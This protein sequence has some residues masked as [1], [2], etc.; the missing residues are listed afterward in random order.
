MGSKPLR[1]KL[2]E[3]RNRPP[4][5][6]PFIW[7]TRELVESD[8]W[9]TAPI[10]TIRFVFRLMVE[11]MAHGGCENG[12][13]VCTHRDCYQWGIRKA[14]VRKAQIDAIQ[15]G[16]VYRTQKGCAST[17]AGRR[18]S[19]FGL[20]WLPG[21]DGAPAPNRWKL[22]I[23]ALSVPP[24]DIKSAPVG[25]GGNLK[26][27]MAG[28]GQKPKLA[29]LINPRGRGRKGTKTGAGEKAHGNGVHNLEL[30]PPGWRWGKDA[31]GRHVRA[32]CPGTPG[33]PW[34]SVPIIDGVGDELERAARA[35]LLAWR[36][37]RGR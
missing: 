27:R 29:S 10:W 25:G 36:E 7:L 35:E 23:A 17:G 9:Q 5:G 21:H 19:K 4:E 11:H 33:R 2:R 12:N 26:T 6:E 13:L 3:K 31:D 14:T 8:A 16:L 32:L 28:L 15:R 18:P 1:V 24:Q 30:L 20:G 22:Y 37:E 34:I